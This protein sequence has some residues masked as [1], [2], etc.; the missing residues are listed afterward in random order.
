MPEARIARKYAR[1]LVEAVDSIPAQ[2]TVHKEI[3]SFHEFCQADSI[4]PAFLMDRRVASVRK[5]EI[6][7]KVS[8]KAGFS[9]PSTNLLRLLARH[10]R[11]EHLESLIREYGLELDR[12]RGIVSLGVRVPHALSTSQHDRLRE[13]LES[14]TGKKVKLDVRR[15]DDLLGGMVLEMGSVRYDISLRSQL[16]RLVAR[17]AA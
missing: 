13:W 11:F 6:V 8:E 14:A 5:E 7:V 15:D 16:Q 17:L 4:L 1:A 9:A 12:R 2:D 10:G 3:V